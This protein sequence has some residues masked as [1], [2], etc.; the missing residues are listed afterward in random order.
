MSRCAQRV[1]ADR[2]DCC[3]TRRIRRRLG[4]EIQL[5]DVESLQPR[6]FH[7]SLWKQH[8]RFYR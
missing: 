5:L 1:T 4:R 8:S 7:Q 2:A 3:P 6:A